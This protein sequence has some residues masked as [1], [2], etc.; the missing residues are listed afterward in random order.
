[1][2]ILVG[3]EVISK[4]ELPKESEV[5]NFTLNS[6][7][8]T[9]TG[10]EIKIAWGGG[11]YHYEIQFNFRCKENNFYLYEVKKASFSTTN[12][13]NGNWDKEESEVIKI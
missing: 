1:M 10:F 3:D 12:P 4:I 13:N 7:E 2:N 11:L 9:E 6:V 5:K 8:K